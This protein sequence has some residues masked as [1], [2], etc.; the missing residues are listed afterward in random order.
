[1]D[2]RRAG[3]FSHGLLRSLKTISAVKTQFNS[4]RS[5]SS[6]PAGLVSQIKLCDVL[7]DELHAISR[8]LEERVTGR[9]TTNHRSGV[10]RR[11]LGNRRRTFPRHKR[12]RQ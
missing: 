2:S 1:M 11:N 5:N 9:C 12:S 10:A 3:P 8:S 4:M 7:L 6:T